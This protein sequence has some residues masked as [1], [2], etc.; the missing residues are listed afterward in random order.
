MDIP[1]LKRVKVASV[2]DLR[3]WLETH[4]GE[5][6]R[7]MIITCDK[8]SPSKHISSASVRSVLAEYGWTSEQSYTLNGNL[9][10]H[11]VCNT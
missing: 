2:R 6:N 11:V 4:S 9:L 8:R 1:K 7:V 10:G 3:V 5:D